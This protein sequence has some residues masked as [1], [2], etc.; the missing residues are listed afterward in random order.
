MTKIDPDKQLIDCVFFDGASN[1]QKAG[2]IMHVH[3]PRCMVYM[4]MSMLCPFYSR[5]CPIFK[6]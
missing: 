6:L 5:N 2:K 4:G 1:V 3:Y